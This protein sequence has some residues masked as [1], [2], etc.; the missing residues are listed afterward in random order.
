MP[1]LKKAQAIVGKYRGTCFSIPQS[2][3]NFKFA[4]NRAPIDDAQM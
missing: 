1:L 4:C 3:K 2:I